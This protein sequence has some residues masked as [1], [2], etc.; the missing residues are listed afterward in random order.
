MLLSLGV[1]LFLWGSAWAQTVVCEGSGT[2]SQAIA[3]AAS[4][5]ELVLESGGIHTEP[6]DTAYH[7][8]KVLTIMAEEGAAEMP[9]L[10]MLSVARDAG[11]LPSFFIMNDGSSLTLR[12]L[13]FDG[14]IDSP[15]TSN[16]ETT[17]DLFHWPVRANYEIGSI[18]LY[19]CYVHN[20]EN[21]IFA[22]YDSDISGMSNVNV[23]T[24]IFES[25]LFKYVGGIKARYVGLD[26]LKVENCTFWDMPD[27]GIY[28]RGG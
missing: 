26:Y 9:V 11:N 6:F 1:I 23:D 13:E 17:R 4:G 10:K 7:I 16:Y 2:L 27:F 22:G 24:L 14:L 18:K 20:M 25:S 15:D 8:D 21:K 28:I 12:G 19:D 5:D 3:D